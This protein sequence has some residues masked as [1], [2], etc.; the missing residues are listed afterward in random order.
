MKTHRCYLKAL[1]HCVDIFKVISWLLHRRYANPF[2]IHKRNQ[3][4]LLKFSSKI[5]DGLLFGGKPVDRS[6]GRPPKRKSLGDVTEGKGRRVEKLT[7][8]K[9]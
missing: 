5:A 8:R 4:A 7:L 2:P 3:M 1:I 9:K 6:V